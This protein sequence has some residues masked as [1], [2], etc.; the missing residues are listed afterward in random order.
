MFKKS[1]DTFLILFI[2]TAVVIGGGFIWYAYFV[3]HPFEYKKQPSVQ[4]TPAVVDPETAVDEAVQLASRDYTEV[5]NED[6]TM[7]RTYTIGS[8]QYQRPGGQYVPI[9]ASIVPTEPVELKDKVVELTVPVL[10]GEEE[11][12]TA[13]QTIETVIPAQP[14]LDNFYDYKNVTNTVKTYFNADTASEEFINFSVAGGRGV[15]FSFTE[16]NESK[17]TVTN[18]TITYPDVY[19][20]LDAKYTVLPDVLLEE[21]IAEDITEVPDSISQRVDLIGVYYKEQDDGSITFHDVNSKNL[22]F[23]SPRPVLYE[24]NNPMN[25]NFGL[26]YEI[27]ETEDGSYVISKVIDE[28]GKQWLELAT[29]PVVIDNSYAMYGSLTLSGEVSRDYILGCGGSDGEI[30]EAISAQGNGENQTLYFPYYRSGL[31]RKTLTYRSIFS[32]DTSSLPGISQDEIVGAKFRTVMRDNGQTVLLEGEDIDV[33]VG[34]DVWADLSDPQQIWN[35]IDNVMTIEDTIDTTGLPSVCSHDFSNE[36]PDPNCVR[37]AIIEGGSKIDASGKT[38]IA[39]DIFGQIIMPPGYGLKK[40]VW[41]Y[42]QRVSWLSLRP[43]LEIIYQPAPQISIYRGYCQNDR[44]VSCDFSVDCSG[45]GGNCVSNFDRPNQHYIHLIDNTDDEIEWELTWDTVSDFSSTP[46]VRT[47]PT[48]SCTNCSCGID[49]TYTCN[50]TKSG[51]GDTCLVTTAGLTPDTLY[52]YRARSQRT[53]E[54]VGWSPYSSV[55]DHTTAKI[56]ETTTLNIAS[57]RWDTL[58]LSGCPNSGAGTNPTYTRYN[59]G[60]FG[61][62]PTGFEWRFADPVASLASPEPATSTSPAYFLNFGHETLGLWLNNVFWFTCSETM[63]LT[64]TGDNAV[65]PDQFYYIGEWSRDTRLTSY[66]HEPPLLMP[67]GQVRS[68]ARNPGDPERIDSGDT[69][70]TIKMKTP[71]GP[72][73]SDAA[74]YALQ[75]RVVSGAWEY[76]PIAGGVCDSGSELWGRSNTTL[77]EWNDPASSMVYTDF[78]PFTCYEFRAKSRNVAT[79]EGEDETQLPWSSITTA[80][81]NPATPDSPTVACNYGANYYCDVTIEDLN[82]PD[83]TQYRIEYSNDAA[84][85]TSTTTN[86]DYVKPG[87]MSDTFTGLDCDASHATYYYRV[88]ARINPGQGMQESDWSTSASDTLP[89]CQPT[90]VRECTAPFVCSRGSTYIDW[91]WDEPSSGEAITKTVLYDQRIPQTYNDTLDP[92]SPYQQSGLDPNTRHSMRVRSCDRTSAIERC[93]AWSLFSS[94]IYTYAANPNVSVSCDYGQ[95]ADDYYCELTITEASPGNPDGTDYKIE[96]C[97]PNSGVDCSKRGSVWTQV[98]PLGD[99]WIDEYWESDGSED[100]SYEDD[101]FSWVRCSAGNTTQ[102]YRVS[103]RNNASPPEQPPFYSPPTDDDT[104][105]PCAP[106]GSSIT[107]TEISNTINWSWSAPSGGEPVAPKGY[108]KVYRPPDTFLGDTTSSAPSYSDSGLSPNTEYKIAVSGAGTD[109]RHRVGRRSEDSDGI[110]TRANQP[111]ISVVCNGLYSCR[112]TIAPNGNPANTQYYLEHCAS[113]NT[114]CSVW[115]QTGLPRTGWRTRL[116]LYVSDPGNYVLDSVSCNTSYYH[117]YRIMARNGDGDQTSKTVGYHYL[118]PCRPGTISHTNPTDTLDLNWSWLAPTGGEPIGPPNYQITT[119]G[120]GCINN[121]T[122]NQDSNTYTQKSG[123]PNIK[124]DI[125]VRGR[126]SITGR[127]GAAG[128]DSKYTAIEPVAGIVFTG[129]Q[130]DVLFFKADPSSLDDEQLGNGDSGDSSGIY[131][132]ATTSPSY[133]STWIEENSGTQGGLEPNTEYCYQALTRNGDGDETSWSSVNCDYTYADTPSR[134]RIRYSGTEEEVELII[135][136]D[137]NPVYTQYAICVTRHIDEDTIIRKYAFADTDDDGIV[138]VDWGC[139]DPT[140]STQATCVGSGVGECNATWDSGTTDCASGND[141]GHWSRRDPGTGFPAPLTDWGGDTGIIIENLDASAKYDFSVKATNENVGAPAQNWTNFGPQATLFLVRNNLVGWAWSSNIGWISLNCLNM[142]IDPSYG[143]SCSPTSHWGFNTDFEASREINPLEGYAW[144]ASGQ[145]INHAWTGAENIS[146]NTGDSMFSFKHIGGR[147]IAIDSSDN[148]HIVW[149]DKTNSGAGDYYELY[150]IRWNGTQWVD[151]NDDVNLAGIVIAT[152]IDDYAAPL[153]ELDSSDQ[154]HIAYFDDDVENELKY[155]WWDSTASGWMDVDGNPG[156]SAIPNSQS[157]YHFS[158]DIYEGSGNAYPYFAWERQDGGDNHVFFTQWNG[159]IWTYADDVTETTLDAEDLDGITDPANSGSLVVASLAVDSS[160]YPHVAW[161]K[162]DEPTGNVVYQYWDGD[163][164][165]FIGSSRDVSNV[166]FPA[167]TEQEYPSLALDSN[168]SPHLAFEARDTQNRV[169]YIRGDL[170]NNRWVDAYGDPAL[171]NPYIDDISGTSAGPFIMVDSEDNPHVAYYNSVSGN[172]TYYRKWDPGSRAWITVSG[173]TTADITLAENVRVSHDDTTTSTQASFDL[174][175]DGNPHIVW[176]EE[177]GVADEIY[178]N[179]WDASIQKAGLGW[180]SAFKYVCSNNT[181]KGCSEIFAGSAECG[182]GGDCQ[183]TSAEL[184]GAGIPPDGDTYGYCFSTDVAVNE[185]Y[186]VCSNDYQVSCSETVTPCIAANGE[187]IFETCKTGDACS[188]YDGELD[189]DEE[190]RTITTA[191]YNGTT[192]EIEGWT[193]IITNKKEGIRQG[194]DDWGWIQLG[195]QY[196]DG[197]GNTGE[198]HITGTEVDSQSFLGDPDV[199]PNDV[200]LYSMFGWGWNAEVTDMSPKSRWLDP[201][202]VSHDGEVKDESASSIAVDSIG[203]P[204]IAWSE[205]N[206]TTGEYDIYYVTLEAGKWMTA[207]GVE[208][209]TGVTDP[210]ASGLSVSVGAGFGGDGLDSRSPSLALDRDDNPHIAWQEGGGF[211]QGDSDVYYSRWDVAGWATATHVGGD[212]VDA[213]LQAQMPS[214]KLVSIDSP[215]MA[216]RVGD[217]GSSDI[218][219]KIYYLGSDAWEDVDTTDLDPVD[220]LNVSNTA[221]VGQMSNFPS[222]AL[223]NSS[224]PHITWEEEGG[225][226]HYRWWDINAGVDGEWVTAS[227]DIVQGT[228]ANDLTV[229]VGVDG[230]G[231]GI[232]IGSLDGVNPEIALYSDDRP[233]IAWRDPEYVLYRQWKNGA[234]VDADPGDGLDDDIEISDSSITLQD[235]LSHGLE[236]VNDQPRIAW[237]EDHDWTQ[238]HSDTYYTAWD[239]SDWVTADTITLIT[240]PSPAHLSVSRTPTN[241][242]WSPALSHDRWGNAHVSWNETDFSDRGCAFGDGGVIEGSAGKAMDVVSDDTYMYI[243]GDNGF[244][245]WRIEKRNLGN[246]ELDTDFGTNGAIGVNG[247]AL[248]PHEPVAVALDDEGY[249][250]IGGTNKDAGDEWRVEKRLAS[251]GALCSAAECGTLFGGQGDDPDGVVTSDEGWSIFDMAYDENYLYIVGGNKWIGSGI[252]YHMRIEKRLRSTGELVDTFGTNGYIIAETET[253]KGYGIAIDDT[254]MYISGYTPSG[255]WTI[256]KRRLSDGALCTASACG[257]AEEFGDSGSGWYQVNEAYAALDIEIDNS[258][259]YVVGENSVSGSLRIEKRNLTR[260]D[261]I[262]GFGSGGVVTL[263]DFNKDRAGH[264]VAIDAGAIYNVGTDWNGDWWIDKFDIGLGARDTDF[265]QPDGYVNVGSSDSANGISIDDMYMYVVGSNESGNWYIE[266]RLLSTGALDKYSARHLY[267]TDSNYPQCVYHN[268][269]PGYEVY[270]CAAIDT[271]YTRWTPGVVRSGIGWIEFM[272]AGALLGIPWVETMYSDIYAKEGVQLAPPPRGYPGY[273]STYLILSNGSIQGIPEYYAQTTSGPPTSGYYEPGFEPLIEEAGYPV[274]E[275][276]VSNIDVDAIVDQIDGSRNK[277]GHM[278]YLD[279]DDGAATGGVV[280]VSNSG[281]FTTAPD[282]I[283]LDGAVYYFNGADSYVIDQEM[284][285]KK[286]DSLFDETGGHGTIVIDGDLEI[287]ANVLYEDATLDDISE[288]PSAAIIVRGNIYV[289]PFVSKLAG[290]F[291]AL[292]ENAGMVST[293]RQSPVNTL[294]AAADDDTYI[295][296]DSGSSYTDH[297]VEAELRVGKDATGN[298]FRTFLRWQLDIPPGSEVREAYISTQSGGLGQ[299]GDF[300]ARVYLLD[301]VNAGPFDGDAETIYTMDVTNS[302][303]QDMTGW[304]TA[305]EDT[306][307]DIKSLVQRFINQDTYESG[308]YI[309]ISIQEGEAVNGEHKRIASIE[310]TSGTH[311]P[312]L[313]IVYSPRRTVYSLGGPQEDT[314]AWGSGNDPSDAFCSGAGIE[315]CDASAACMKVGWD[316]ALTPAAASRVYYNFKPYASYTTLPETAEINEAH[317]VAQRGGCT[318]GSES[319]QLRQGLIKEADVNNYGDPGYNPY[320]FALS[321]AVSEIAEDIADG[322]WS[323]GL[324]E[325][326]LADSSRLI[327]TWVDGSYTPGGSIGIRLRRGSDSTEGTAAVGEYRSVAEMGSKLEIDY[328]APLHVSGLLVARGYNFDRKYTKDLAAA[329]QI[330]YDGRVV[331]NTPPGLSD[332]SQSLPVYQRVVP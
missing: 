247:A 135:S 312:E 236:I 42:T 150:Y 15:S 121:G 76:C 130:E 274:G 224:I 28:S 160:G 317:I 19:Q 233:G 254:Y 206:S 320:N 154:P 330:V 117:H 270:Y 56:Q 81:T 103:V 182:G 11:E 48:G 159:S 102:N 158:F 283:V 227:G 188:D 108:Y 17:P 120:V 266:K 142:F 307:R 114:S 124:C 67:S 332:F 7:T 165:G 89:P 73:N 143:F 128:S 271:M 309:G 55:Y 196:D 4:S 36:E 180:I 147:T 204:H 152:G 47:I 6:G 16:P 80:C 86:W 194:Y 166:L 3:Q 287:N 88:Q 5:L 54:P 164:W 291:V 8:S 295:E 146:D 280:D 169:Y 173:D 272:P 193:R 69:T 205:Y 119:D 246:G 72:S 122:I 273:T 238:K 243:V 96:Y 163:S 61:S 331:A 191:N 178:Y 58:V 66:S 183:E 253:K 244:N 216:Y 277:Y 235:S 276:A 207:Y 27:T 111:G 35:D 265:N 50:T 24:L 39:F 292:G 256:E 126:G 10:S 219:Y 201:E 45:V 78:E 198:Y 184:E 49:C 328:Y 77:D 85:T 284:T 208:Y 251:T 230:L 282:D 275:D 262:D 258:Y 136:T 221:G 40:G 172:E 131:F 63:T 37:E 218:Y 306:T 65:Q 285:F 33:Y 222:L 319:F 268:R 290:V 203:D 217:A 60:I 248:L 234:W 32:F 308:N 322:E 140:C 137:A 43:V 79:V 149:L 300:N 231:I 18:D 189:L 105:P 84:F 162:G 167:T 278:V 21:L 97:L 74:R 212:P 185:R 23:T 148:P 241:Y 9:D 211:Y 34:Q 26:H 179:K 100:F 129:W 192:R 228:P 293:S 316:D 2:L 123:S 323:G 87:S 68:R 44:T 197:Q 145:S 240:D 321:L 176:K 213:G 46:E 139:S 288:M 101:M 92:P 174:D 110:Y 313:V 226:I 31:C 30:F 324:G 151:I 214:L 90:N 252:G 171:G 127:L 304:G 281:I 239:G 155:Q 301:T 260:G 70:L 153:L 99:G 229:N 311:A 134:P 223:D 25:V 133:N 83:T 325:F 210:A 82:N 326:I 112:I 195:G 250:Y 138:W 305:S 175:S 242:S 267:C 157:A 318:A 286:G 64:G 255:D 14:P 220:D 232:G 141:T 170:T 245:D 237:A 113:G 310:D 107:A 299:G 104:L 303:T 29:Y 315:E 116:E 109:S 51:T 20:E 181:Q 327:Q 261:F 215:T 269:E 225:E 115:S 297:H 209:E 329:E 168:D 38:Q 132:E 95:A 199:N 177:M 263:S 75:E 279:A 59:M 264:A 1:K 106:D 71:T 41:V 186:G 156:V 296:Y 249:L 200:A 187:C 302:V 118:P 257:A 259:M 314:V 62:W 144:S 12:E 298:V 52:Y 125:S 289:S 93:G 53:D 161:R 94:D 13:E 190:C 57:P 202:N 98:V 22:V 294:I 91:N